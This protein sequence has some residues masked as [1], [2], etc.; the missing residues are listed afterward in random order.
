M[1]SA[2]KRKIL[3]IT[4]KKSDG[5]FTNHPLLDDVKV[6]QF[7]KNST[8]MFWKSDI[9]EE[10]KSG[11]FLQKKIIVSIYSAVHVKDTF[12]AS[13]ELNKGISRRRNLCPLMG[14]N[15]TSFW[16]SLQVNVDDSEDVELIPAED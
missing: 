13:Q 15:R 5:K 10:F 16:S 14:K 12:P 2:W 3:L 1:Q 7:R 8:K 11:D 6:V 4:C 9:G